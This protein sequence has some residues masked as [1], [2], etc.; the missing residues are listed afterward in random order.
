MLDVG[1]AEAVNTAVPPLRQLALTTVCFP[2]ADGKA[3]GDHAG[4]GADD[5]GADD[6]NADDA[7]ADGAGAADGA[8]NDGD[9]DV[10]AAETGGEGVGNVRVGG[11]VGRAACV[12]P[13]SR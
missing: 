4:V 3:D 1:A 5:G 6:G 13:A 2:S 8:G 9:S 7:T 12:D 10:G 11:T